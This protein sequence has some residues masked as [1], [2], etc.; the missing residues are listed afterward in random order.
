LLPQVVVEALAAHLAT[1]PSHGFVFTTDVG[2]PIR[3]TAFSATVWRP[4]V[5]R[6]GP[7]DRTRAA[8]DSVLSTS[9]DLRNP[10]A[11]RT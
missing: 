7:D 6:A 2:T 11:R 1:W 4:A 3:R 8:I 9:E 5:R 10:D